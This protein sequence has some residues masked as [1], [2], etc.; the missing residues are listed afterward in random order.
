[1]AGPNTLSAKCRKC[2]R[3]SSVAAF[4][5]DPVYKMMVCPNCVKD[6]R[7][8]EIVQKELKQL[9][10]SGK[11]EKPQPK[12]WDAEDEK[13]ERAFKAKKENVVEAERIDPDKIKYSCPKCSYKFIYDE[14]RKKPNS[15]PYCGT[16]IKRYST[17]W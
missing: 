9:K 5:L 11:V 6:R 7:S 10:E 8:Q 1:M 16:P 15:C 12:G 2:Q 3:P 13:L 14:D 17:Q 4:V